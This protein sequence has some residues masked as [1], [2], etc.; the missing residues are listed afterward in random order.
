MTRKTDIKNIIF[1]LIFLTITILI[2]KFHYERNYNIR[3]SAPSTLYSKEVKIDSDKIKGYPSVLSADD[4]YIVS[5]T[6]EDKVYILK[7]DKKGKNIKKITLNG[8]SKY[9]NDVNLVHSKSLNYLVF[10]T[11]FDGVKKLIKYSFDNQLNNINEINEGNIKAVKKISDDSLVLCYEDKVIFKNLNESYSTILNNKGTA[12]VSGTK[13]GDVYYV[14]TLDLSGNING[15]EINKGKIIKKF[16]Y[17][18]GKTSSLKFNN[19]ITV[20]DNNNIYSLLELDFKGETIGVNMLTFPKN[21]EKASCRPFYINGDKYY[22]NLIAVSSSDQGKF[23]TITS[24]PSNGSEPSVEMAEISIKDG[25]VKNIVKATRTENVPLSPSYSKDSLVFTTLNDNNTSN[26]YIT[27]KNDYFKNIN[28]K[29]TYAEKK[30]ALI[31]TIGD[32]LTSIAFVPVLGIS[33]MFMGAFLVGIITFIEWKVNDLSESI[34]LYVSYIITAIFKTFIIYKS[35]YV[36]FGRTTG[37]MSNR[38]YGCLFSLGISL[39]CFIFLIY[40]QKND[41]RDMS[42]LVFFIPLIIDT[43]LTQILFVP[44]F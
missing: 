1:I 21:G 35:V 4:G 32:E 38:T 15:A 11:Y 17:C 33:W 36:L 5:Y 14:Q 40:K 12:M 13:M 25:E 37:I 24:L 9:I 7:L 30:E 27:S 6:S 31:D 44:Y 34:L 42:F 20:A 22:Y 43:I 23:I 3:T 39:I 41:K 19:I 2:F 8:Y 26:L 29:V 16:N 28:N 10:T 18:Y